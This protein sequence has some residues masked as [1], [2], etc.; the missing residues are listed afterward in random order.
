MLARTRTL[1]L[2]AFLLLLSGA[3]AL[4]YQTLWIK[5]LSLVVGVDVYAVTTAVS[6]FFAGLA[7]GGA[8]F[9]RRAETVSRPYALYAWLEGGVAVLGFAATIAL[10]HAAPLFATL[11]RAAGPL[12]WALPFAL[13]SAPAFFMG[14]TLPVLM[15]AVSPAEGE[16]GRTGAWLYA[17]NTAGAIAGVLAA[18]FVLIPW[19][20]VRGSAAAAAV[21]NIAAAG[22]ALA[23][24]ARRDGGASAPQ[25]ERD[26]G[27]QAPRQ[28][29]SHVRAT[30]AR[31]KPRRHE[32]RQPPLAL[33]LYAVAGGIALGYEVVW[34]HAIVQFISTRAFAF[35]IM[36]A[37]YLLGLTL[38][39]AAYGQ[40]ADRVRDPWGAFGALIAAA[41]CVAV[42]EIATLGSWLMRWQWDV[43]GVV[44]SLTSNDTAAMCARFAMASLSIVFVPSVLLGAAFP[45]AVRLTASPDRIG[46][47]VGALVALNT[48]GSIAGTTLTGFV[49]LPW[50]GIVGTLGLLA[51]LAGAVGCVAA[52][53]GRGAGGVRLVAIAAA[54]AALVLAL[55]TPP[56]KIALLL[57][58][59]RGGS[60]VFY[61]ESAGGTVA[62]VEQRAERTSFRRLYIQ[63]VSNSGDA[64]TS[65][66]YMRMQALLPLIVHAGEP[67]AA[68]VVGFGTGIT[69]GALLP[70][71]GLE[72]RVCAELLP[73]VVQAAP[74]F[75]GNFGAATDRRIEVRLRD[76][77]RELLRGEQQYDVITLEPPPPSAAGVV[78]L[79]SRDFYELARTRLRANGLLA[80]WWPLPTQN[81]DDSRSLVRSF[82][83]A[84]PHA[85]VWT[86]ELHE[87]LLLGSAEPMTL[88]VPA[89]VERF[90]R[91]GVAGSLRQVGI[92]SPEA[93]LA[94]WVADRGGLERFAGSA[95]AVTDDNPRIEYASWVR[96]NEVARVLPE[97]L[98]LS[99]PPALD[100]AD[101]QFIAGVNAERDRLHRFYRAALAAYASDQ[102]TAAH[103][104]RQVMTEDPANPYYAWFLTARP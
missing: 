32:D 35:S 78:N 59:S 69:A 63:G 31:L 42:L 80:Q 65:Q 38:G 20:G 39:S 66:R 13:V 53:R 55:R 40:A 97:M 49:L 54:A 4:I 89:I 61:D 45:A 19:L 16:I 102:A 62:V 96:R 77:R 23:I 22:G 8:A 92:A 67:R 5:Q 60:L 30:H 21:L 12:A 29:R 87:M 25:R 75:N 6:A 37:T 95:A 46:R 44:R 82:L 36:L 90:N 99:T 27:P 47:D 93:L 101:A 17:A 98:S 76:G 11:E 85:T 104:L 58:A 73:A 9:G 1:L 43:E 70:F 56:D 50:L 33:I 74:L 71:S 86:T 83:D 100:A 28:D 94:T 52:L 10:A 26:G 7:L 18:P 41:G 91:P 103:G 68:L 64:L 81:A 14:G 24:A 2:P 51:V 48:A 84:F 15:R 72:Q 3:A 79:Y 34:S 88:D 57:T